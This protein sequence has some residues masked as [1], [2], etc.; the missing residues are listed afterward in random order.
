MLF[1]FVLIAVKNIAG[2]VDSSITPDQTIVSSSEG[3]NITLT[4]TYDQSARY[5]HWYRQK[6]QSEPE[7]LLLIII[8]TNDVTKAKQPDPRLS[9]KLRKKE[10]KVDLEI[11]PAAVSDSALY[12]CA[13]E[14]TVTQNSNRLYKKSSFIFVSQQGELLICFIQIQLICFVKHL[15]TVMIWSPAPLKLSSSCHLKGFFHVTVASGFLMRD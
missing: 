4:C 8:S 7:F 13:M 14:P 11:F 6:P 15:D 1:F 10:K 2:A 12:Y 5:L 3:S 9:I